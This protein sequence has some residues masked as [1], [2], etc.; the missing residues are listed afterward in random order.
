MDARRQVSCAASKKSVPASLST[1]ALLGQ[2]G[3][4]HRKKQSST[5]RLHKRA[6]AESEVVSYALEWLPFAHCAR[7]RNS[8]CPVPPHVRAFRVCL[9]RVSRSTVLTFLG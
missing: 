7:V 6:P 4:R 5:Q 9:P 2:C 3:Y 8:V 1:L